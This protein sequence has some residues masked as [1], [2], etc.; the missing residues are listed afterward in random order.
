M[1]YRIGLDVGGTNLS[2]GVVD[3]NFNIIGRATMPARAGRGMEAILEDFAKVSE[4]A[5][6]DAGLSICDIYS[7]GIGMPSY[8]NPATGLLVYA[9]CF[10]WRNADIYP[11]LKNRIKLP[12]NIEND[13]NCAALGEKL[14]GSAADYSNVILL[15]LGTGLGGG[16]ILNGKIYAGADGLGAELGHT[17]LIFGGRR[18][19]CGQY[20]CAESYC[21]ATALLN[22]A[23]EG[24]EEG[25]DS[26]LQKYKPYLTAKRIFD[27]QDEDAFAKEL[28]DRYLDYLSG[29]ISSFVTI[30]RPEAIILGGGISGAGER[31]TEPLYTKV[32]KNCFAAAEIGAPPIL[33]ATLGNDAGIIGAAFLDTYGVERLKTAN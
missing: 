5:V 12:I 32:Q 17:K 28:I 9:N 25:V 1:R 11:Y 16:I 8:I 6:R 29:A 26:K 18:C 22:M 21:S 13:A 2:A 30:F 15:T 14:A 27:Y 20:G 24:L 3:E 33:T 19:T 10:G 31:I 23:K 7:W 4:A